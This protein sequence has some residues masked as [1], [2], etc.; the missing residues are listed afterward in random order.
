VTGSSAV[1]AEALPVQPPPTAG[2]ASNSPPCEAARKAPTTSCHPDVVLRSDRAA[3]DSGAAPTELRG[4]A[5]VAETFSG[6][7][8]VPRLALV[9]GAF[10]AVWSQGGRPRV[11]FDFTIARGKIVDI[12]LLAD[13]ERLRQLE[14]TVLRD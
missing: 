12:H 1:F 2:S 8:R 4:A 9:N 13:P 6:R 3:A 14:L 7:A 11:V 10:G 5:A